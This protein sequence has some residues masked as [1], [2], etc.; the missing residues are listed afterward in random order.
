M[1]IPAKY[2]LTEAHFKIV[3]L[4]NAMQSI[5]SKI[6]WALF[7]LGKGKTE[8]VE[9]ILKQARNTIDEVMNV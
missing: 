2:T 7:N 4:E 3:D 1:T 5:N 8:A 6:G 9:Y